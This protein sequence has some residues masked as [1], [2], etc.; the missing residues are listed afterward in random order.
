MLLSRNMSVYIEK[1]F[2]SSILVVLMQNIEFMIVDIDTF[3]IENM[4][5]IKIIKKVRPQLPLVV[6][7]Q[8]NSVESHTKLKAMG[9]FYISIK[10]V[11]QLEFAM[12]IDAI[13]LLQT[14]KSDALVAN[15]LSL[16]IE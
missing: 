8:D 4:D 1:S 14:K 16:D 9:I 2:I 11:D 6:L 12:V 3:S 5:F 15:S 10:P 7:S 13:K